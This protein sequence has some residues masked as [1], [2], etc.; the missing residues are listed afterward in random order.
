MKVVNGQAFAKRMEKRSEKIQRNVIRAVRIAATETRNVAIKSILSNPRGGGSVTRYNPLRT[1]SI[2]AEGAAPAS[3][4]GFL[5]SNIF[6]IF[7]DQGM[8]AAVES[9]ADYSAP[10]EFGTLRMRARPFLQPALEQG[11]KKYERLFAKA[12][13]DAI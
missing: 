13:K 1:V 2:S 4:T 9:R 7:K 11:R 10:L 5:A 3:D 8:S 12:V 6:L